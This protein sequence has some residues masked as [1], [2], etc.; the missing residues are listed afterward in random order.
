MAEYAIN[1]VVFSG[2]ARDVISEALG[3]QVAHLHESRR[4]LEKQDAAWAREQAGQMQGDERILLGQI[5]RFEAG[6]LRPAPDGELAGRLRRTG[7][8]SRPRDP[9]PAM[10]DKEMHFKMIKE[11][12]ADDM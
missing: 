12:F 5:P 3:H 4:L 2:H 6:W 7:R 8:T 10:S 9:K 1:L 11:Q